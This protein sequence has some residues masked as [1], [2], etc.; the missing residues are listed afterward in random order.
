RSSFYTPELQLMAETAYSTEAAKPVAY[1]YV[2]FAGQPVAQIETA[3]GAVHWY[4]NDHLG[5]P[6]LQTGASANVVWRVEREPYGKIVAHRAGASRHQPLAFPGQEEG[7]GDLAY[8]LFR[9]YR[10]AWGRYTQADPLGIGRSNPL[11]LRLLFAYADQEPVGHV[12]QLGLY[13]VDKQCKDS[14]GPQNVTSCFNNPRQA[15]CAHFAMDAIKDKVFK[16]R[17]CRSALERAGIWR[18]MAGASMPT[19][20]YPVFICEPGICKGGASQSF[21]VTHR[22]PMCSWWFSKTDAGNTQSLF[23]EILHVI[24]VHHDTDGPILGACFEGSYE[25]AE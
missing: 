14:C 11:G 6:V 23:H 12:D 7:E 25:A 22:I 24:G 21:V 10:T 16:D 18:D 19:S 15:N 8:N 5:T 9:W 4:F 13:S 17:R 1:E 2:W 20:E 3:T